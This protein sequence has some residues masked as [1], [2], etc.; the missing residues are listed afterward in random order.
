M[1]DGFLLV[2]ISPSAFTFSP[3]DR[4]PIPSETPS[5]G[6]AE[7]AALLRRSLFAPS[8]LLTTATFSPHPSLVFFLSPH[9]VAPRTHARFEV[10]RLLF[11]RCL[12]FIFELRVEVVE[13]FIL[14]TEASV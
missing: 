5:F 3:S 8:Q 6:L 7:Y 9:F 2:E 10:T 11:D 4:A 1:V 13:S 12:S 14:I